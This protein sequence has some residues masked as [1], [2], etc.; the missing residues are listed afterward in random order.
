MKKAGHTETTF[1]NSC[2]KNTLWK[3]V[4]HKWNHKEEIQKRQCTSCMLIINER[5]IYTEDGI[6]YSCSYECQ[7]YHDPMK[8]DKY[9]EGTTGT[10]KFN[11]DNENNIDHFADPDV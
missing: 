6:K 9:Q 7:I 11:S 1:C 3:I 4:F 8:L 2:N 10:L 5:A